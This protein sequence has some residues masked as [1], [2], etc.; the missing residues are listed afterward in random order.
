MLKFNKNVIDRQNVVDIQDSSELKIVE[1]YMMY[2]IGR[3]NFRFTKFWEYF[4]HFK[5]LF[6]AN[7]CL[8]QDLANSLNYDI[9][10]RI[11]TMT[12]LQLLVKLLT[13]LTIC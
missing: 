11:K 1:I 3:I 12:F 6:S 8:H 10:L 5:Y 2:Y 7:S 9:G 4:F 13:R